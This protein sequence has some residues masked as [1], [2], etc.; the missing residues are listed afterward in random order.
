[1]KMS[2][3]TRGPR[4]LIPSGAV[5]PVAARLR[6]VSY[7][8]ISILIMA[9]LGGVVF[10]FILPIAWH[11]MGSIEAIYSRTFVEVTVWIGSLLSRRRCRDGVMLVGY[12]CGRNSAMR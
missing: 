2:T 12:P 7:R 5:V 9:A 3:E 8:W 11:F 4:Q 10:E 1:M 6:H